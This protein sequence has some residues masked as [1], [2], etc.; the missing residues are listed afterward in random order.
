VS[1]DNQ[2]RDHVLKLRQNQRWPSRLSGLCYRT[3]QPVTD[4]LTSSLRTESKGKTS[5]APKNHAT[6]LHIRDEV[7]LNTYLTSCLDERERSASRF[8]RSITNTNRT[9]ELVGPRDPLVPDDEKPASPLE[10]LASGKGRVVSCCK[11][12]NESQRS[13][14]EEGVFLE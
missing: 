4:F 3:W 5:S 1:H 14:K 8:G 11:H 7:K 2:C 12:G 13:V 10:S 9:Q 6:A